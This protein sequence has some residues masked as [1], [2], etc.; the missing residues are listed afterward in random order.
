MVNRP[1]LFLAGSYPEQPNVRSFGLFFLTKSI[2]ARGKISIGCLT[3]FINLYRCQVIMKYLPALSDFLG[4]DQEM[5]M[6]Y[7]K[8]SLKS[9]VSKAHNHQQ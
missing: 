8:S 1:R 7:Y 6:I 3:N 4:V 5:Y 2:A 9:K